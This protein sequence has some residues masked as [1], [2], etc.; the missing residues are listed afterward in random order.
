MPSRMNWATVEEEVKRIM[1]ADVAEETVGSMPIS[2]IS[3]PI[4]M[5]PPMPSRPAATPAREHTRG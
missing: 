2:S 3:G 5:P 4:T 1:N